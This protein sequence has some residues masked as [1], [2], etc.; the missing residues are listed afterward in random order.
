[1]LFNFCYADD[2]LNRKINGENVADPEEQYRKLK[3]LEPEITKMYKNGQVN[4]EKYNSFIK[5][6]TDYER[7]EE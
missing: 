7:E 6:I 2:R 3:K 4:E 5:S 1:M